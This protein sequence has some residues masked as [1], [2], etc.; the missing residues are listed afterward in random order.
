M[1]T[2]TQRCIQFVLTSGP[3]EPARAQLGLEAAMAAIERGLEVAVF[4]TLDATAWAA[5][6]RRY[7][8]GQAVYTRI[9]EVRHRG[10]ELYC[11]SATNEDACGSSS[12]HVGAT[13]PGF[14][15]VGLAALMD[16]VVAG[17]PTV[18]F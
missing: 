18:T 9:D 1:T 16:R 14:Q 12:P 17:V 11:C 2:L 3:R 10:G 7:V 13:S 5:E 6:P 8:G 15:V 4:L